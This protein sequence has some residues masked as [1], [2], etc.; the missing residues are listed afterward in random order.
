ER[1]LFSAT[2]PHPNKDGYRVIA[3][4]I[5][6]YLNSSRCSC[7]LYFNNRYPAISH[8]FVASLIRAIEAPAVT[9]GGHAMGFC[10]RTCNL[11]SLSIFR[12]YSHHSWQSLHS[13]TYPA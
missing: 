1:Y 4:T 10:P 12:T 11:G 9:A 8:T 13:T 6:R 7:T 2:D 3:E 5:N